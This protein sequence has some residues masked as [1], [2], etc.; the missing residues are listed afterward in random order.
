MS[1][2]LFNSKTLFLNFGEKFFN[3]YE[4]LLLFQ[5]ITYLLKCTLTKINIILQKRLNMVL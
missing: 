5:R 1:T 4:F 2:I 3:I